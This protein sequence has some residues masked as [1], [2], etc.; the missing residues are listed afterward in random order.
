LVGLAETTLSLG[1]LIAMVML[2]WQRFRGGTRLMRREAWALSTVLFFCYWLPQ[3]FSAIDAVDAKH[4]WREVL[5]D[6]RYL[7]FLWLATMAVS[8][9]RGRKF[10]L[11]SLAII[12]LLW[13]LDGLV[14]VATGWSP[15]AWSI[16][17]LLA[18]VHEHFRLTAVGGSLGA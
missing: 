2:L 17:R 3:A 8:S 14:Q 13:T 16:D 12:V 10:C 15:L 7:P 11:N 9:E 5:T 6:L 18:W 4:A 1:A